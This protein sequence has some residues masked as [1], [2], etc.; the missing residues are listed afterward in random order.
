MFW[1]QGSRTH[2]ARMIC[3]DYILG[4]PLIIIVTNVWAKVIKIKLE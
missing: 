1:I 2:V 3:I 4:L